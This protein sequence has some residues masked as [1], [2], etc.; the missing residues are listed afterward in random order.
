MHSLGLQT[1][2]TKEKWVQNRAQ[3]WL[4][5]GEAKKISMVVKKQTSEQGRKQEGLKQNRVGEGT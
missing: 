3:P 4:K 5:E 1:E 2:P